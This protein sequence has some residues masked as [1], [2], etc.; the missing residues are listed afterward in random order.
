[1][2]LDS[3]DMLNNNN[4]LKNIY[5]KWKQ[6]HADIIHV[7]ALT[8]ELNNLNKLHHYR[9]SQVQ[10]DKYTI[11]QPNIHRYLT[12]NHL[13]WGKLIRRCCYLDAL[14]FVSEKIL[15]QHIIYYDDLLHMSAIAPYINSI[16]GLKIY[17]VNYFSNN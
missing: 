1:M 12:K 6:N 10:T 11:R 16:D 8:N 5:N 14:L 13:H 7:N 15:N 2:N 17:G 9:F 3:D 4:V